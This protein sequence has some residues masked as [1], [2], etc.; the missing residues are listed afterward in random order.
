LIHLCVRAFCGN[1]SLI[2]LSRR[3]VPNVRRAAT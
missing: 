3:V 2:W 1:L